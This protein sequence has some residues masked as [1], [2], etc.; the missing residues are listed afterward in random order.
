VQADSQLPGG[1]G[2]P[3]SSSNVVDT[4]GTQSSAQ[5]PAGGLYGQRTRLASHIKTTATDGT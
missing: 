3:I 2:L 4:T 5:N 1:N